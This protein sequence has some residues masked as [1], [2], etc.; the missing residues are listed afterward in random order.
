MDFLEPI[1]DIAQEL[2]KRLLQSMVESTQESADT[3]QEVKTMLEN[4]N[5][6][7]VIQQVIREI[8][9]TE[10]T[11]DEP[12][13]PLMKSAFSEVFK[14]EYSK[15]IVAIKRYTCQINTNT[16]DVRTTFQKEIETLRRF[17][18]PNILR[19]FGICI[20]DENGPYPN[21][22][23]VMEYCEMGNL[24]EVLDS[25][26]QMP[27]NIKARMSLDAAQGLYR[28]HQSEEKFKVHGCI[29]SS[30]FL[31]AVGYRVK[32][33]GFELAK[34][35]T[36][37]RREKDH[38]NSS[39]YYSCPQK[40]EDVNHSYSTVCEMYSFGIVLWEIAT[41]KMPLND[42][43]SYEDVYKKVCVKKVTEPLPEDCPK[44]LAELIDNCRNYER[45]YRPSAGV[46]VDKLRRVVEQFKED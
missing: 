19:M 29:N 13:R 21:Y 10:L 8:K 27:W 41:R 7:Q 17:E 45:F 43:M 20:Q 40:L 31:V 42:C 24:R 15:F 5:K 4:L 35:E 12:K 14:G 39:R 26:R 32:L 23:I 30:K 1:L 46:L 18:S 11:F 25:N 28:L 16:W 44:N 22:L 6:P 3:L 36:S 37:L 33:A 2:Y 34:T 9:A 38:K